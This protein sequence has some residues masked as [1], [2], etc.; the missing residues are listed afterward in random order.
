[1][2]P[3]DNLYEMLERA[4]DYKNVELLKNYREDDGFMESLLEKKPSKAFF[5]GVT[6]GKAILAEELVTIATQESGSREGQN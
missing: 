6:I 1:M 5:L 3:Y 4:M 2:I